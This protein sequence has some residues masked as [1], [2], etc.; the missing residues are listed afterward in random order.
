V[1]EVEF[2][3]Q[4]EA[5]EFHLPTWFGKEVTDDITYTNRYLAGMR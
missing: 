2:P 1:A 5:K 3:S 4:K